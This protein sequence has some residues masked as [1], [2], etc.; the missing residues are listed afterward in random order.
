MTE[1]TMIMRSPLAF[2]TAPS[3][4]PKPTFSTSAAATPSGYGRS[5]PVTR[6]RRRGTDNITP[7]VPPIA[8]TATV[9]Q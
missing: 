4:E 6:A 8:Q 2:S 9:V 7:S 1:P 5:E 3:A